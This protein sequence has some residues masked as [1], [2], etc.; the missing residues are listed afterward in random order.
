MSK[1]LKIVIFFSID[2]TN[3]N[4]LMKI[5]KII[6]PIQNVVQS[7][8]IHISCTLVKLLSKELVGAQMS[9]MLKFIVRLTY[10]SAIERFSSGVDANTCKKISVTIIEMPIAIIQR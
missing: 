5:T 9:G 2:K 1:V 10:K 7:V 4:L 6:T 3:F 8:V